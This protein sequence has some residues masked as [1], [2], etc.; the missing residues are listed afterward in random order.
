[1]RHALVYPPEH[2]VEEVLDRLIAEMED[3][4]RL[5]EALQASDLGEYASRW[6]RASRGSC[7]CATS[8]RT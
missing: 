3:R 2:S 5:F 4:Y 7:A 6:D 8:M 1:M